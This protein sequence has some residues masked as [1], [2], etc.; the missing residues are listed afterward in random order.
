[1]TTGQTEE[2]VAT[3]IG[4]AGSAGL[5]DAKFGKASPRGP[6][7]LPDCVFAHLPE[8]PGFPGAALGLCSGSWF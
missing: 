8:G 2:E 4:S 3:V 5:G 7:F 1:M 6:L